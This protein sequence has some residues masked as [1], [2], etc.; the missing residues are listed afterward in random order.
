VSQTNKV[1]CIGMNKTGTTTMR[2]CFKTLGLEPVC[3]PSRPLLGSFRR[4]RLINRIVLHNDYRAALNLAKRFI[5]FEDRPWNVGKMYAH[6]NK[7]FRGSNFILT[8]RDSESW[9]NSVHHWLT[10]VKPHMTERYRMHLQVD[11]FSKSSFIKAYERYTNEVSE[12]FKGATNFLKMD[13]E[14]GD[15]WGYTLALDPAF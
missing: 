13:F 9:W 14:K 7:T 6:L 5:S 8:V 12:Y 4:D 2:A 3:S 15:G 11:S 1:F 10:V